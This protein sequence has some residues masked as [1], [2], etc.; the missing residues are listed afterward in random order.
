MALPAHLAHLDAL[1]DL[2]VD[3]VIADVRA[4][5]N[6]NADESGQEQRR[7]GDQSS[8]TLSPPGA[9]DDGSYLRPLRLSPEGYFANL[10]D[11]L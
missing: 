3:A 10:V 1:L 6:E 2:L 9:D 5:F 4:G 7:R 11:P 8:E